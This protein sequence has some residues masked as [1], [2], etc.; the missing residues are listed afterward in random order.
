MN[1]KIRKI[2][3]DNFKGI[4]HLELK[5][6]EINEILG[7]N[8]TGKT[9]IVTAYD[10]VFAD[11]DSEMK[12]NPA[13]FNVDGSEA[14]PTVEIIAD[15]DGK[16]ITISR[17]VKRTIRA[18]KTTGIG[19][20]VSFSSTYTV[21]AVE[22]GL[23]DFKKKIE[24]YGITDRFLTLSHPDSFISE[25]KDDI[26]KVLFGMVSSITDVDI[27]KS[28]D[29]VSEAANLLES[30]SFEEVSA[31][32]NNTLRKIK[33]CYGKDGELVRAKIEALEV[34]KFDLD[35]AEL[36]LQKNM[37]K[38]KLEKNQ[39]AQRVGN[40][41]SEE[42]SKINEKQMALQFEL[43]GIE[44]KEEA[45]KH[46]LEVEAYR[47]RRGMQDQIDELNRSIPKWNT[48]LIGNNLAIGRLEDEVKTYVKELDKVQAQT[49]NDDDTYC[50]VCHRI[51]QSDKIEEMKKSCKI[52]EDKM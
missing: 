22:Y 34:S 39:D 12:S 31:M 6:S 19:D 5:L 13:V 3:I 10:W 14:S 47:K 26:R 45:E 32:Q 51:F 46:Q 42:L 18:S 49:F 11:C 40:L 41:I 33:E 4:K 48:E 43:S 21:N 23:K 2:I 24:E 16:E 50:P 35:F 30:Y 27:A 52:L 20:S 28:M 17:M 15:I 25:K 37:L 44:Q 36:E 9:T 1:L 7:G 29:G 38:E 8:G